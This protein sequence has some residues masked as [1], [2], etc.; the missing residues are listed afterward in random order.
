MLATI[1]YFFGLFIF[2][3]NFIL[4]GN[5]SKYIYLKDFI[6]SFQKVTQ[7]KPE[8]SDFSG[9]DWEFYNFLVLSNLFTFLWCFFGLVSQNWIIF[10]LFFAFNLLVT[11]L[12][13]KIKF[14]SIRY[15]F[16]LFRAI[17]NVSIIAL[18]VVNHFH[19]HLNLTSFILP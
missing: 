11:F 2:L 14:Y 12:F 1:F 10:L 9:G 15:F 4:L 6:T 3:L 8:K 13:K 17:I 19:L 5:V 18:L 16:E 7:K